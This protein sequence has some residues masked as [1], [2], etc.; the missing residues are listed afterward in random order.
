MLFKKEN[1][2]YLIILWLESWIGNKLFFIYFK[3]KNYKTFCWKKKTNFYLFN[4]APWS[5]QIFFCKIF[6]YFLHCLW[7]MRFVSIKDFVPKINWCCQKK[8]CLAVKYL[9]LYVSLGF[10]RHMFLRLHPLQNIICTL[11][12]LYTY[13]NLQTCSSFLPFTSPQISTEV[14]YINFFLLKRKKKHWP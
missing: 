2:L 1:G 11:H 6:D 7:K 5:V 14:N 4:S 13:D 8:L 3:E 9:K 12:C 10:R